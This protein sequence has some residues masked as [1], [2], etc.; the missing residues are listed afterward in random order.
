MATAADRAPEMRARRLRTGALAAV[1]VLVLLAPGGCG[2]PG[3]ATAMSEFDSVAQWQPA[4][5]EPDVVAY[6]EDAERMPFPVRILEWS[7]LDVAITGLFG[8]EPSKT[9]VASPSSFARERMICFAEG[10]VGD[11]HRTALAI[12]RLS[13]VLDGDPHPLNQITAV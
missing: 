1:V 5:A 7:G 9:K 11:A 3:F 13:W 12:A 8:I 4:Q 10:A 6:S 2:C